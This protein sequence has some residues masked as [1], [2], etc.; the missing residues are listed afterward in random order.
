MINKNKI[1]NLENKKKTEKNADEDLDQ[2]KDI[3]NNLKMF[4]PK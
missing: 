1:E 3:K 2:S 4:V